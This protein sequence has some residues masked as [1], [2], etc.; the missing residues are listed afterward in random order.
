M[1]N[2]GVNITG[3]VPVKTFAGNFYIGSTDRYFCVLFMATFI[4]ILDLFIQLR[5]KIN[6]QKLNKK[7]DVIS[8]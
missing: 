2:K 7:S 6:F 1:G 4:S 5:K 8:A 3:T